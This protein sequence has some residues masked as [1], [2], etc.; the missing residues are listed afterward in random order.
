MFAVLTP[1]GEIHREEWLR[2]ALDVCLARINGGPRLPV[3]ADR[4]CLRGRSSGPRSDDEE[5]A[6]ADRA[7]GRDCANGAQRRNGARY[8]RRAGRKV[9]SR[10]RARLRRNG[11]RLQHFDRA[12]RARAC[13]TGKT[14]ETKESGKTST[15]VVVTIERASARVQLGKGVRRSRASKFGATSE[16]ER[17]NTTENQRPSG[18]RRR[19]QASRLTTRNLPCLYTVLRYSLPSG[20]ACA[21]QTRY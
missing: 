17:P 6:E 4:D 10:P 14:R 9:P 8:P 11:P 21:R 12:R 18:T 3:P 19:S 2:V 1:A 16:Q 15:Q 7:I 5:P 20:N 13:A